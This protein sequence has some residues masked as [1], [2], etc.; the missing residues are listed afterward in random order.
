MERYCVHM[1]CAC[2]ACGGP[3]SL[4][5]CSAPPGMRTDDAVPAGGGAFTVCRSCKS[6]VS[7]RRQSLLRW[8]GAS[9]LAWVWIE[10]IRTC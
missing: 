2:F 5:R 9:R 1:L 4:A 7:A 3:V 6:S 10:H 8:R